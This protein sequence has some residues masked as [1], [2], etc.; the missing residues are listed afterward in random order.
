M[1]DEELITYFECTPLPEKLRLDMATTQ[2]DV[3]QNVKN[4]LASMLADPKD[5]HCRNRLIKIANAMEHPYD[6]PEIPGF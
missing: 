5:H 3:A 6:G 4:N 2:F 1:T